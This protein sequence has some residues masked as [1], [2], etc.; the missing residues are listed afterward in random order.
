MMNTRPDKIDFA[1]FQIDPLRVPYPVRFYLTESVH[2][3]VCKSRFPHKSVNLS[4]SIT[5]I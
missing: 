3:V 5:N 2:L 4:I 1:Y